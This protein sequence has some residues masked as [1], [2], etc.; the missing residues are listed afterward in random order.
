MIRMLFGNEAE[1][2][3]HRL[4]LVAQLRRMLWRERLNAR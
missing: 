1:I 4:E 3:A 2:F